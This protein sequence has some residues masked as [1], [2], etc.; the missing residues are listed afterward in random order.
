MN[1][2]RCRKC[3]KL[4]AKIEGCCY[5]E[6]KCTRCGDTYCGEVDVPSLE[7]F[8]EPLIT[9]ADNNVLPPKMCEYKGT[10]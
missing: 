8:I 6:I 5:F 7:N 1:D 4:L 9:D 3:N 10:L 2:V